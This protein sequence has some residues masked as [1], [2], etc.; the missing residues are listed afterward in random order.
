MKFTELSLPGLLLIEPD[1]YRDERG[2]FLETFNADKYSPYIP[3]PFIQD[4]RSVSGKNILRGLHLQ[5]PNQ[6]GKLVTV[7]HGEILDVAVDVRVGSPTFGQW[8]AQT[9]TGDNFHQF[10]IPPGYAHGFCVLSEEVE[11][12][13]K[14]TNTYHPADELVIIWNDETIA[15]D[16]PLTSPQLSERDRNGLCLDEVAQQGRLPV[17]AA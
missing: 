2:F 8:H 10:Y 5:N 3:E 14:C 17:Y 11:V 1:V 16:W 15:I 9:L 6:Q 7:T 12:Q 13:Y 4:N